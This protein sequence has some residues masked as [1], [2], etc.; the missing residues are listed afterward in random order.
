MVG[1]YLKEALAGYLNAELGWSETVQE[2]DT[3]AQKG[4][5]AIWIELEE[6]VEVEGMD[7]NY[8]IGGEVVWRVWAQDFPFDSSR[9]AL[10][11]EVK[12]ALA[13]TVAADDGLPVQDR[14]LK[15]VQYVEDLVDPDLKVF[16]FREGS[17]EWDEDDGK[18]EGR[19]SFAVVC[20]EVVA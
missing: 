4:Q 16:D 17:G 20:C 9:R 15:F 11:E 3:N 13:A 19:I 6:G 14:R 1:D 12:D 2:G 7:G 5:K 8:E 18:W 10:M